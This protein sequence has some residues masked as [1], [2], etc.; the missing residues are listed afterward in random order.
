M[1]NRSRKAS[2]KICAAIN[3]PSSV[4]RPLVLAVAIIL[5]PAAGRITSPVFLLKYALPSN[6]LCRHINLFEPRS[7]SSINKIAPRRIADRTGPSR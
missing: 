6:T 7:I 4:P 3:R 2:S 5:K 1:G